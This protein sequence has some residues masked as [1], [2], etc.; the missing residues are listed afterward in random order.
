MEFDGKNCRKIG[1]L[2]KTVLESIGQAV[3]AVVMVNV[4]VLAH[5]GAFY[6]IDTSNLLSSSVYS[7]MFLCK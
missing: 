7:S 3:D 6:L 5:D 1:S 4:D 2:L